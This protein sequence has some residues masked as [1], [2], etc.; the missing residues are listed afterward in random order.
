MMEN[1]AI[2]ATLDTKGEETAY[3]RQ[4]VADLGLR[5]ILLDVGVLGQPAVEPDLS[6]RQVAEAAGYDFDQLANQR[7]SEESAV[8]MT[9]GA[10]R[11]LGRFHGSGRLQG[12]L[13]IGGARGTTIGIG[14]MGALPWGV[15]KVM[16]TA[17]GDLAS[18]GEIKDIVIV[19]TVVD[20][21]GLNQITRRLLRQAAAALAGLVRAQAARANFKPLVGMSSF[22]AT[23]TAVMKSKHLLEDKGWEVVAF[24]ATGAGGRVLE[25]VALD[26]TLS[27]VL[28]LTITELA[29]E[30]VGGVLSAGPTRLE[31]AGRAE[32][33]QVVA[34]GA[35]DMVNFGRMETVPSR[36]KDRKL[37]QHAPAVTLMRTTVNENAKLGSIVAA[38]L[39][40]VKSPLAVV[41]PLRGFS[42]YDREGEVFY[43]PDADA[44]FLDNLTRQ[45]GLHVQLIQVD[46]HINDDLFADRAVEVFC[47][48]A[49]PAK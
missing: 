21:L 29:D 32:I 49:Q 9:V 42:A 25:E 1:I 13:A 46:C 23:T 34:P 27:G 18:F 16:V 10:A 36:F 19:P 4:Q 37:H 11:V 38:K 26:G 22:G 47:E 28:D 8:A 48:L 15:P 20:L 2:L 30:L 39:N 14:A 45:L 40:R 6:R 33:P 44:A 24:P 43:D 31:A 3:L 5:P 35:I 17:A 12:V 41:I 7:D